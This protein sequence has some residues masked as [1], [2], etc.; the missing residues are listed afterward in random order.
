MRRLLIL[1]A[2]LLSISLL[3]VC[4]QRGGHGGG[5]GSHGGFGGGHAVSGGGHSFSGGG[6]SGSHGIAG[7]HMG[8][9]GGSRFTS[10]A[11]ANRGYYGNRYPGWSGG[12]RVTIR[13]RCPGCFGYGYGYPYYPYYGFYDPFWWSDSGYDDDDANQRQMASQMNQENL[14]EQQMLA[15]EQRD[16]DQDM[17]APRHG[18]RAAQPSQEEHAQNDPPTVL[19]FRDQHQREIQNYAITDGILWNFAGSHTEKIPL[20]TLDIPATVKANDDRG[21]DFHLPGTGGEGQ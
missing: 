19:V 15:Q 1:A 20:A 6:F 14:E 21:I 3:P 13:T 7:S 9:Y 17:Y 8:S 5:G 12:T 10:R 16:G 2:F 11:F 18:P 4:A